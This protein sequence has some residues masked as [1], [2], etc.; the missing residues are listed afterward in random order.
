VNPFAADAGYRDRRVWHIDQSGIATEAIRETM[1][2]AAEARRI[3]EGFRQPP[4]AC[5]A[6]RL[7][8]L[9]TRAV[10]A[11]L[12]RTVTSVSSTMSGAG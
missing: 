8:E 9:L 2:Q 3:V 10:P 5:D 11:S 1:E 6:I 12:A 4:E 7:R